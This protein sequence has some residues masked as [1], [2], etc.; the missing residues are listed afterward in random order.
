MQ[1]LDVQQGSEEWHAARA[2]YECASEAAA[3]MGA[4]KHMSRTDLLR[5]KA[6]GDKLEFSAWVQRNLLDKGHEVEVPARAI[7]EEIIGEDLYPVTGVNGTLLA[8]FDGLT[9]D[10]TVAWEHKLWNE[11]LAAA[12]RAGALPASHLWQLEHQCAVGC[13]KVLFMVSDGTR[14]RCVWMWYEP[15]LQKELRAGWKQF[16]E[17]V[18]DYQHVEII[19]AAKGATLAN[20]PIPNV[21]V[22]GTMT[23]VSDLDKWG[24]MLHDFIGKMKL[25][26]TT[27]QDFAHLESSI[28]VLQ[29]AQDAL[30]LVEDV[31]LS[32]TPDID[33]LRTT[34]AELSNTARDTRLKVEKLVEAEKKN[35]RA[36]ILKEGEDKLAA[37]IKKLN[38][39]LGKPFM[40]AIPVDFADAMKGKKTVA[41]LRDAVDTT[42]AKA[43]ITANEIADRLQINLQTL[44]A[45]PDEH[46]PLFPDAA[47]IVQKAADDLGTLIKARIADAQEAERKRLEAAAA[48]QAEQQQATPA[49][50]S[51]VVHMTPRP[52]G[53]VPTLKLGQIGERLG[54]ALTADFLKSLGFEGVRDRSSLL[55]HETDFP[56][57]CATLIQH[58]NAV[59]AKQAA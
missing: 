51:T 4:S 11:E 2:Q 21:Q 40:P 14:E 24:T 17:D 41:S 32:Q 7:A 25:T 16:A 53:A 29:A 30:K 56:R 22:N 6:T 39:R 42:L 58:I 55:F 50:A 19:P 45:I 47:Q 37:H 38:E 28:K 26:P 27:D 43:K 20:L 49:P 48:R 13:D 15:V 52:A 35:I 59:Q 10:E 1:T 9:M 54:F 18:R 36:R 33:A 8:S 31:A 12:V 3:M 57:I 46:K 34:V 5:M 23:V 44:A